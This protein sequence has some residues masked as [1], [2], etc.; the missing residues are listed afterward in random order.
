MCLRVIG[1]FV[2]ALLEQR[3]ALYDC[4]SA[5]LILKARGRRR[6]L[7][8]ARRFADEG[9]LNFE[10]FLNL[11]RCAHIKSTSIADKRP[12]DACGLLKR[13]A[14]YGITTSRSRSETDLRQ[15]TCDPKT[16]SSSVE[17]R[18]RCCRRFFDSF[19]CRQWICS[20]FPTVRPFSD[21]R[22]LGAL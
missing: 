6:P 12:Y 17:T 4:P 7:F 14:S 1:A 16:I 8:R 20:E 21:K 13:T 5:F 2:R 10:A 18:V 9:V 11:F 19:G 15:P 3:C 22:H